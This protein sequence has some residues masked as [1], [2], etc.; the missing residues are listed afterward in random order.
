MKKLLLFLV[1]VMLSG[2]VVFA[3]GS[4][5]AGKSGSSPAPDSKSGKPSVAAKTLTLAATLAD[6]TSIIRCAKEMSVNI[7]ADTNNAID[8]KVFPSSTLGAQ[9]DFLEGVHMGTVD[10]CIIAAGAVE[11]FYPKYAVYSVPFLFRDTEH[12]YKFFQSDISKQMNEEFLAKTGMRVIGLFNEGYRQV[13]T[14]K[15]P[16]AS[17]NDFKG[18]KMRV[19]D[20]KLYVKMFSALGCNATILPYGDVYTGLQT[21]LIDGVE[22]PIPSVFTG[23]IYEQ[24]KF[25]T[26][27][28]H[29]GGPMFCIINNKVWLSLTKDQQDSVLKN[30]EKATSTDRANLVTD[31]T[32]YVKKMKDSGIK[33]TDLSGKAMSDLASA[34]ESVVRD[35]YGDLL[36]KSMLES[37]RAIK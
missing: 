4:K 1:A 36:P 16:I 25:C 13:W 15:V 5:E 24:V 6:T 22:L 32:G 37:I 17:L 34:M 10:M 29:I 27:T 19:P 7:K 12:A 33:F 23:G 2:A 3:G 21:G 26:M 20:V 8:I 9:N 28:S 14:K 11:N 30:L 18:L 31:T 35:L